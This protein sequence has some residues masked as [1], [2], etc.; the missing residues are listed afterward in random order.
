MLRHWRPLSMGKKPGEGEGSWPESHS[1]TL[2]EGI[3]TGVIDQVFCDVYAALVLGCKMAIPVYSG[4][5]IRLCK[6]EKKLSGRAK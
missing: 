1:G 3:V 2:P 6:L 4:N 5:A